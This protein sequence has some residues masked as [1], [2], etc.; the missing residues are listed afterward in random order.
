MASER[1]SASLEF[2]SAGVLLLV[3]LVYLVLTLA[4]LQAATFAAEGAV[5]QAARVFV[6]APTENLART[7]AAGAIEDALADANLTS[8]QAHS[9]VTCSPVPQDC[10]APQSWVTTR[11]AID[12][13]LPFVPSIFN[14]D[15]YARVLISAEATER[16]A[17]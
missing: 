17:R 12:V 2:V 1:G 16:V 11:T 8:S 9:T 3:P 6:T 13:P 15:K 4:Q 10:L 14:L 5:R 7:Y